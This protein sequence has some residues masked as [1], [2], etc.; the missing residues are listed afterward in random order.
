MV[1]CAQFHNSTCKCEGFYFNHFKWLMYLQWKFG[2]MVT[3]DVLLDKIAVKI[4]LN[5]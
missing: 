3:A 4:A 5:I 1:K 2:P